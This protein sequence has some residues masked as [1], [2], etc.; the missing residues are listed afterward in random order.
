LVRRRAWFEA[1]RDQL[2]PGPHS[3]TRYVCPCCGYPT[4]SELG[5]YDI[6]ELCNWED[7]GQDDSD[8]DD[9]WGG[10]NYHY[11]L[12]RARA[13]FLRHLIMYDPDAP[14]TR[15]SGNSNTEL[16][17]RAKRAIVDAFDAM[18]SEPDPVELRRLW[19]VVT[20]GEAIL[21]SELHRTVAEYERRQAGS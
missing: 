20:D 11:S 15:I 3:G 6:C 18:L 7:D 14:T 5:G 13:N 17:H 19:H 8:A 1:Y 9:V 4:L 21:Q 10:P 2:E 12:A 16:E